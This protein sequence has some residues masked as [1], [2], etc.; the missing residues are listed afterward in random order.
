MGGGKRFDYPKYV[1][2]PT[3]GWW[4]EP[5]NWKRNTAFAFIGLFAAMIPII[6]YD[7]NNL[8]RLKPPHTPLPWQKFAKHAVEDDPRLADL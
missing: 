2:S 3:G 6:Y 4:C 5:R 7:Y 8:R 1:W